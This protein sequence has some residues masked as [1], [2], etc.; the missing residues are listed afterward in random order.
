MNRITRVEVRSELSETIA[1]VVV[2]RRSDD[3]VPVNPLELLS[4]TP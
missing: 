3:E 4:G 2:G 1:S